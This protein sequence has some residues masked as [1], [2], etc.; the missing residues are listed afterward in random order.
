LRQRE[1]PEKSIKYLFVEGVALLMSIIGGIESDPI[2]IVIG[3]S[4]ASQLLVS[5]LKAV[6]RKSASTCRE[7]L[8]GPKTWQLEANFTAIR[9]RAPLPGLRKI[10]NEQFPEDPDSVVFR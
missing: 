5:A 10:L 4:K 1:L 9:L 3:A 2:L 6:E 8:R 7:Q